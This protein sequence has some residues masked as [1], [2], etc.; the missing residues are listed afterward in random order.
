MDTQTP[1]SIRPEVM[2]ELRAAAEYAAKK[3]RDPEVMRKTCERMDR[4]AEKNAKLY[5]GPDIGVDI[6][7]EMRENRRLGKDE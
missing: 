4:R 5:P 2:A 3:V 1:S 7:R 6:I